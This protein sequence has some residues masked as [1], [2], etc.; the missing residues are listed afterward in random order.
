MPDERG[1][2]LYAWVWRCPACLGVLV[3]IRDNLPGRRLLAVL[4]Q[5]AETT[6]EALLRQGTLRR[7]D[8]Q[9]AFL[10]TCCCDDQGPTYPSEVLARRQRE[11]EA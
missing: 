1:P 11:D 5:Q 6:A 9:A 4:G 3:W 8:L 10:W 2:V 7:V